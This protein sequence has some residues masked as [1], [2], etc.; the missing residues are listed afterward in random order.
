MVQFYKEYWVKK[1]KNLINEKKTRK[2]Y[3]REI[4]LDRLENLDNT[5]LIVDE[6]RNLT[7]N[8]YELKKLFR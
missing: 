7:G 5:L 1:L 6:A 3:E 8:E 4:P 2:N